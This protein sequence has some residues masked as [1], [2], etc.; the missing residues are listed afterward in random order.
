M[1]LATHLLISFIVVATGV[2]SVS[3]NPIAI[4]EGGILLIS[5]ANEEIPKYQEATS[6]GSDASKFYISAGDNYAKGYN[7][8]ALKDI[9]TSIEFIE[10]TRQYCKSG[11]IEGM[12]CTYSSIKPEF[13]SDAWNMKGIILY[14]LKRYDEAI[15]CYDTA[16]AI[17]YENNLEKEYVWTNKGIAL[18]ELEHYPEAIACFNKSIE[19]KESSEA[20]NGKGNSLFMQE[21]YDKAIEAFN[22][23]TALNDRYILAWNNKGNSH[24][25]L[26][27]YNESLDSY[28]RVLQLDP[29]YAFAW[30]N[31]GFVLYSLN[32]Y[33][34]SIQAYDKALKLDPSYA[35][36]WYNK[37]NALLA[38]D[39]CTE[40][41]KCY[42]KAIDIDTKYFD[43]WK[44]KARASVKCIDIFGYNLSDVD[45]KINFRNL[46]SVLNESLR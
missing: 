39:N 29:N 23:A 44:G 4:V 37:G 25:I 24:L 32:R 21:K 45:D 3:A 31:K 34:E 5:I 11:W 13:E 10:K 35:L 38:V 15:N 2:A 20:W 7:Y 6:D 42:D 22:K 46:R 40:A 26:G 12:I 18:N 41:K 14:E 16:T 36:A 1:K 43:A 28:N 17:N 27:Q 9:N 30:N 8:D 33:G 19:I